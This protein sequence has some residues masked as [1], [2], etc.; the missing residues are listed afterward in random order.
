MALRYNGVTIGK[1]RIAQE[2]GGEKLH[3]ELQIR[4]GNCLAVLLHVRKLTE[5][6][7]KEHPESTCMHTLYSFFV[8]EQHCKNIMK[9]QGDIMC[10]EEVTS[11][12]L[13]MYYKECWTLLKYFTKSGH[14]VKCYYKEPKKK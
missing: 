13:N 4:Q 14:K 7:K 10:G 5:E 11:V 12:E 8:D 1:V 6:E 9:S 2:R 3:F